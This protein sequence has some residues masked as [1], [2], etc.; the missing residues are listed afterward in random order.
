MCASSIIPLS[1]ECH[2]K[3]TETGFSKS[4]YR[5]HTVDLANMIPESIIEGSANADEAG[6]RFVGNTEMFIGMPSMMRCHSES[7]VD[8]VKIE[9]TNDGGH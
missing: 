3:I 5:T 2:L 4:F 8:S 7:R 1:R 9:S 6:H